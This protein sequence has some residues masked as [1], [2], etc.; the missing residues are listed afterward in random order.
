MSGSDNNTENLRTFVQI[1]LDD[2][3]LPGELYRTN[4]DIGVCI[5]VHGSGS[6]RFSPRYVAEV[7][8]S[9]GIAT[10]LLDLLTPQ[11]E[12]VDKVTRHLRFN[13]DLLAKR[14]VSVIDQFKKDSTIKDLPIGLFGAS[15][16]GG[17]ALLAAHERPNEVKA[18]ISR[19][20]RPDLV[21]SEILKE[22]QTP[23]LFIVGENDPGVLNLNESA[24]KDL[25]S[26]TKQLEILPKASHLF[27][28]PGCIE[29]VADLAAQWIEQH[30]TNDHES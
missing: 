21:N 22:I 6:S 9:H 14:V 12:Q 13:I 20:G 16:G 18:I 2:N 4:K 5:F 24:L 26:Q 8:R 7:L 30:L 15:T 1:I 23:T 11:E 10:F 3:I 29:K 17:A 28:E 27:E 19:G 25:G